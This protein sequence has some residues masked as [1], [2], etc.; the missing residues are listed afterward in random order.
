MQKFIEDFY[1]D[2]SSRVL[3]A[4]M[5]MY[6]ILGY[7]GIFRIDEMGFPKFREIALTQEPSKIDTFIGYVFNKVIN[8]MMLYW[9]SCSWVDFFA[10]RITGKFVE[11][12]QVIVDGSKG[13]GLCRDEN[14]SE[15]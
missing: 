9:F 3:R 15:N 6:T 11:Y 14:H 2:N 10:F 7:I 5:T 8:L 4:D 12:S 1:R 13:F